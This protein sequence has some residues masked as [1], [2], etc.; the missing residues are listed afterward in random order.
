[1]AILNYAGE[2]GKAGD[3]YNNGALHVWSGWVMWNLT[4]TSY[5]LLFSRALAIKVRI[6]LS[7]TYM[8]QIHTYNC[9]QLLKDH[10]RHRMIMQWNYHLFTIKQPK[11]LD[12]LEYLTSLQTTIFAVMVTVNRIGN[13]SINKYAT[14][15][16]RKQLRLVL[17]IQESLALASMARDDPPASSTASGIW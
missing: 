3:I 1:L 5:L 6:L 14:Q 8:Q 7:I 13:F 4:V 12:S 17:F 9:T 10:T 11:I 15:L 16:N 2:A